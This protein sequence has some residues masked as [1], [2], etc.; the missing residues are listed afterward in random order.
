MNFGRFNALQVKKIARVVDKFSLKSVRINAAGRLILENIP[1]ECVDDVVDSLGDVGDHCKHRLTGCLGREIC[2]FGSQDTKKMA[3]QL[4][5]LLID[6]DNTPSIIKVGIS[7]CKRCCG[8]S[9]VR[10]IGLIGTRKGWI[11]TFGGNA[12][13]KVRRGDEILV[14]GSIDQVLGTTKTILGIYTS[15]A[16][17]NERTARFVERFG[18]EN[19]ITM[20]EEEKTYGAN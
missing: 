10:D 3:V 16:K 18:I 20:V 6:F 11:L 17:G 13:N 12:G 14:D 2:R 19:L 8:E 4:E 15:Q 5:D 1:A 9:Y 7:G